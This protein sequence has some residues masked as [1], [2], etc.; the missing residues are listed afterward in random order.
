M[1]SY[2]AKWIEPY[3]H[4]GNDHRHT[5]TIIHHRC[6]QFPSCTVT[7]NTFYKVLDTN[8]HTDKDK[9]HN[10]F[11]LFVDWHGVKCKIDNDE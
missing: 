5:T 8:K 7:F 6:H 3:E 10:R 4:M 9:E 2:G 11:M 1:R